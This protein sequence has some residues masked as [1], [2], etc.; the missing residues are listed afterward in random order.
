MEKVERFFYMYETKIESYFACLTKK[1][2]QE[3]TGFARIKKGVI[4]TPF[5]TLSDLKAAYRLGGLGDVF[6]PV[7]YF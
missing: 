1:R 6:K 2:A 5:L 3:L 7:F 4:F